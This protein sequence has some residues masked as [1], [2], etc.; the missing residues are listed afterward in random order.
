MMRLRVFA[1]GTA[2]IVLSGCAAQDH[3]YSHGRCITCINNPITGQPVNYDPDETPVFEEG[4]GP[5]S[6]EAQRVAIVPVRGQFGLEAPVDVDT[7]FARLRSE[8]RFRSP[9]DFNQSIASDR[10]AMQDTAWHYDATPGALYQLSD[11][12]RQVIDGVEHYIVLKA[13]IQRDGAGSRVNIQFSNS[14]H[15]TFSEEEMAAALRQRVEAA[16]R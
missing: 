15:A 7:A 11:Y 9:A 8:F 3:I 12:N 14:G 2:V 13:Q 16:L 5:E 4:V 10:W 1:L 6:A